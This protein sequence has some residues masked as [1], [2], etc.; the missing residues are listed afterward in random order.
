ML[1]VSRTP[2]WG[3]VQVQA[4]PAIWPLPPSPRRIGFTNSSRPFPVGTIALEI[5]GRNTPVTAVQT[6]WDN[7]RQVIDESAYPSTLR[8]NF[9]ALS[10]C[11]PCSRGLRRSRPPQRRS[12]PSSS[13]AGTCSSRVPS[14]QRASRCGL[15]FSEELLAWRPRG[16]GPNR[17]PVRARKNG[18]VFSSSSRSIS[19][20]RWEY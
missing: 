13:R 4:L 12:M 7:M 15:N 16:P 14:S 5:S 9:K 10:R 19:V 18:C 20:N 8:T 11:A 2:I 6:R 17:Q 1:L 3:S